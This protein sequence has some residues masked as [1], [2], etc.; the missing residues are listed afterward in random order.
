MVRDADS[1]CVVRFVGR[2]DLTEDVVYSIERADLW[3]PKQIAIMRISQ[4]RFESNWLKS[5]T[6]V[7]SKKE[8]IL[9]ALKTG[10]LE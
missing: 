5:L 3:R 1:Y 9:V 6:E 7:K 10:L 8:K 2:R 4:N